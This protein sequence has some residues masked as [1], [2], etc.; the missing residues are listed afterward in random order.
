MLV[1]I[2]HFYPFVQKSIKTRTSEKFSCQNIVWYILNSYIP[3]SHRD[4]LEA[5]AG[6]TAILDILEVRFAQSRVK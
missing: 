5:A 6:G 3:G 4:K 2:R 1:C